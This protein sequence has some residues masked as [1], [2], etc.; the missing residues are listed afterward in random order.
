MNANLSDVIVNNI[1]LNINSDPLVDFKDKTL[2]QI[3]DVATTIFPHIRG[4]NRWLTFHILEKAYQSVI[5]QYTIQDAVDW[6][7][8]FVMPPEVHNN[9][10]REL[11]LLRFDLPELI[12]RKQA[13]NKHSRLSLE[14]LHR[15]WDP[16]DPDFHFLCEFAKEG[17]HVMT[18]HDFVPS[19]VRPP[20]FSPKYSI[21][22]PAVNKLIYD[23]YNADLAVILPSDCIATLPDSIP[24]HHSRLGH[25][26]KKG[27]P[28]GRVTSNY[29]YGEPNARLNTDEVREMAREYYGDIHLSTVTDLALMILKQLE[30]AKQWG[31]TS[32]DLVLW[33][34]DLKGA[35]TLLFFRPVDC[36]LLVLTM[37]DDLSYIPISGNL[38]CRSFLSFL[39]S[40]LDVFYEQFHSSFSVLYVYI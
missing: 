9:D 33:T 2:A 4:L 36:G 31:R 3:N 25:T 34:M 14:R 15:L 27:K 8:G 23:S 21:A 38:A 37:T 24:V 26:L 39:M 10:F 12:R 30:V 35:F 5:G 20:A 17:V 29:S 32:R 19:R 1:S 6:A 28:E 18:S 16:H 40:A 22:F 11:A 13:R 7:D